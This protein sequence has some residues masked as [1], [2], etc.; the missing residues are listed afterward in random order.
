MT[1]R[2]NPYLTFPG[3]AREALEFYQSAL[4]GT[5]VVNTFGE[6]GAPDPSLADK[7]MHGQL[8]TGSGLVLMGADL[9]PGMEHRPGTNITVSLSGDE[10][11]LLRGYWDK[12]TDGATI[13]TPLARQ[14]WGDE[15]GSFTDRFGVPWL[16]NIAGPRD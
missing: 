14:M 15:Y 5:L 4:G 12:L 10:S 16:V 11:D 13:E 7:V 8:E 3:T 9:A 2:L 1:S 6:F